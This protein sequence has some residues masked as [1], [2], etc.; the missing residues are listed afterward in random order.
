MSSVFIQFYVPSQLENFIIDPGPDESFFLDLLKEIPIF[1]FFPPDE[2][3]QYQY[4]RIARQVQYLLDD[5]L[6][7]LSFYR[8]FAFGAMGYPDPCEE[9][10]EVI[11]NFGLCPY[12]RTRIRAC[13]PLLYAY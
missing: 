12:G 13:G 1:T 2:R 6:R 3:C 7:G 10:P 11:V 8:F 9:E 4:L 5:L